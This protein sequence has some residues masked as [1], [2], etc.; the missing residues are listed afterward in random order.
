M[1]AAKAVE[2]EQCRGKLIW[3][4]AL[5]KATAARV[6]AVAVKGHHVGAYLPMRW[7]TEERQNNQQVDR[8]ARIEVAWVGVGWQHQVNYFWLSGPMTPQGIE[9]NAACRWAR[10]RGMDLTL[11]ATTQAT[12]ER[13]KHAL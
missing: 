5:R 7:A 13:E 8:A 3:A 11:D 1:A 2:A 12:H 10:G 4:A 6:V 9:E